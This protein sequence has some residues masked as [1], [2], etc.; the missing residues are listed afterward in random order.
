M[1]NIRGVRYNT[2]TST[3][4]RVMIDT[5]PWVVHRP[6]IIEDLRSGVTYRDGDGGILE[7]YEPCGDGCEDGY[8]PQGEIRVRHPDDWYDSRP[9]GMN[10]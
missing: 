6:Q 3:L 1:P 10:I 8:E 4:E 9:A 5:E 7:L 2:E